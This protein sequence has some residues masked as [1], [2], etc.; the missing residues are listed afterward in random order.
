MGHAGPARSRRHSPAEPG[1]RNKGR[2]P[3]PAPGL[4]APARLT[5]GP[6]W[7]SP[8]P[9]P[10][11]SRPHPG[12]GS[13]RG[14]EQSPGVRQDQRRDVCC[15]PSP[16]LSPAGPTQTPQLP[17]PREA[18]QGRCPPTARQRA[19]GVSWGSVTGS[20][21]RGARRPR[22]PRR[23]R[24]ASPGPPP[25]PRPHGE[26]L[27]PPGYVASSPGAPSP[28]GPSPTAEGAG[29]PAARAGPAEP[30]S[31][32]PHGQLLAESKGAGHARAPSL[33]QP[34]RR[35][36][37]S[38]HRLGDVPPPPAPAPTHECMSV[39]HRTPRDSGCWGPASRPQAGGRG[40]WGWPLHTPG[41]LALGTLPAVSADGEVQPGPPPGSHRPFVPSSH[42]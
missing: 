1:S 29:G 40:G 8:R 38:A 16:A 11:A 10:S 5:H 39:G 34:A 31:I 3:P 13:G 21:G 25:A 30:A 22:S 32:R 42:R 2:P 23:G 12:P 6:C 17:W 27:Q 33:A 41:H 35:G 14:P 20:L 9:G 7:A 24:A 36:R 37:G 18:K 28:P 15:F 4:P 26:G 19:D